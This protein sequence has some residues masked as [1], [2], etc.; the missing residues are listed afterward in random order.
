M[1]ISAEVPLRDIAAQFPDVVPVLERFGIDYCCGGRNTLAE[2]CASL[3]LN[4]V[5]VLEALERHQQE[6]GPP[7]NQWEQA[8]LT[9][10]I[11]Y[12]V[13]KHHAFTRE[14]IKL[15][16]DLLTKVERRH[17]TDHPEIFQVSKN[18]AV[19][20]SEL[21]HHFYCEENVLFPYIAQLGAGQQPD[22]PPVFGS[23]QQPVSRMMLEHDQTRNQLRVLRELTNNY[24]P[25]IVVCATWRALYRAL[26]D[27]ERDLHQ[28]IHL[29]NNI[30]FP[31]ALQK[32][33]E[34]A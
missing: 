22:L 5:S 28:H 20:S 26:E 12:I 13:R 14:Q 11:E 17:G 15:I 2:A 24:V 18:F 10:M 32:T 34:A 19:L 4:L 7:D 8:L 33:K 6:L 9:E 16:D 29:E 27:L 31:R 30:L 3:E 1:V 25:P 23:V 21:T